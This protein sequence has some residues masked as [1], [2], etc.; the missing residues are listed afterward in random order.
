MLFPVLGFWY[1][2]VQFLLIALGLTSYFKRLF[3]PN[4]S[5]AGDKNPDSEGLKR[6]AVTDFISVQCLL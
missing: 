6:P 4:H 5:A 3:I 2:E 1:L